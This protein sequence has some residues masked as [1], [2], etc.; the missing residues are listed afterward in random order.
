ME[1]L[2][3]QAYAQQTEFRDPRFAELDAMIKAQAHCGHGV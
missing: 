2:E 3:Q 1:V